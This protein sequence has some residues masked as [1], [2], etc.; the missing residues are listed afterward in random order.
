M[1]E[2]FLLTLEFEGSA[3]TTWRTA[4]DGTPEIFFFIEG[5]YYNSRRLQKLALAA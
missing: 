5:Y 4:G 2:S 1:A 3:T